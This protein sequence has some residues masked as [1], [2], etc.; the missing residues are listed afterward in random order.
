M[1]LSYN[2][3]YQESITVHPTRRQIFAGKPYSTFPNIWEWVL[4]P[5]LC[6]F[7]LVFVHVPMSLCLCDIFLVL[8]QNTLRPL[9]QSILVFVCLM[10]QE[11]GEGGAAPHIFKHRFHIF[12]F[13]EGGRNYSLCLSPSFHFSRVALKWWQTK[14]NEAAMLV[15]HVVN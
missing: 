3:G 1:A 4:Y 12:S 5:Y 6:V 11:R 8:D 10:E 14:D 13:I 7:V 9:L 15:P 2:L